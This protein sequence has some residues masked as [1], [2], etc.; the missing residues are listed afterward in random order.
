MFNERVKM[1]FLVLSR[2]EIKNFRTKKKHIVISISDPDLKSAGIEIQ[3]SSVACLWLKFPD[4]DS[5][6][7]GYKYNHRIFNKKMAK[8]IWKFF[9][10]NRDQ[11]ELVVCQCEAGISRSSAVAGALAKAIG[12]DDSE[13]F[14]KYIPNRLVYRILLEIASR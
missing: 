4:F 12:Q 2:K 1:K 3:E 11:I 5:K 6:I 9:Q 13:F 7:E 8:D 14:K 10:E